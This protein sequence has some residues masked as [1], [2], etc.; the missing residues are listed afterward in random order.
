MKNLETNY[1]G[2]V[3]L[4]KSPYIDVASGKITT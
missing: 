1:Y 2:H 3:K 4:P